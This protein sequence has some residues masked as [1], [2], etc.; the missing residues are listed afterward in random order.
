VNFQAREVF[1]VTAMLKCCINP[2][3]AFYLILFSTFK[4]QLGNYFKERS[5]K[6]AETRKIIAVLVK[7]TRSCYQLSG[8]FDSQVN[9]RERK[10]GLL[11]TPI[12]QQ[13]RFPCCLSAWSERK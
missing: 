7:A 8:R 1:T 12:R 13:Q 9:Y 5:N 3:D 2:V 4:A 6:Q 10:H 11:A